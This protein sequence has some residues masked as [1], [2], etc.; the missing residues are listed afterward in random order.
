MVAMKNALF[1]D[2]FRELKRTL[3]RFLSIFA[4]VA[5][6]T[7]FFAGIKATSPDMWHTADRYYD[8]TRLEDIRLVSTLGFDD[9]DIAAIRGTAGTSGIMPAY[10][11]DALVQAG[12]KS[13]VLRLHSYPVG[14][15]DDNN[16]LNK[17]VVLEGRLPERSGECVT[18]VMFGSAYG[19]SSG[20]YAIG[21]TVTVYSG[22]DDPITDSL[23]ITN[24]KVVGTVMSPYY[25]AF[26]RGTT[27]IGNGSVDSYLLI[28]EQDFNL[29][30]Y[31]DVYIAAEGARESL[32]YSDAY[33][34]IIDTLK[35]RFEAVAALR[36]NQRYDG[37]VAEG[38]RKLN[39]AKAE[40]EDGK[41]E[42][43]EKL[44]KARKE[45]GD[46]K[47]ELEDGWADY[48][49]GKAEYEKEIA[50]GQKQ[51][52]DGY[53]EY[54]KNMFDYR[55]G[56]SEFKHAEKRA[57]EELDDAE[58]QL[59]A[60]MAEYEQGLAEYT[61]AK[62]L[63]DTLTEAL[64]KGSDPVALGTIGAIAQQLQQSSETAN[65]AALLAAYAGDPS[66]ENKAMA[67]GATVQ[68]GQ[69]L[70][71]NQEKLEAAKR[72]LDRGRAKISEGYDQL[73][74]GRLQLENAKQQL[75]DAKKTLDEK[76][77][78][79]K[80]AKADGQRELNDAYKK[81]TDGEQELDKGE[82]E[83]AD[84]KAEADKKLA[85]ARVKIE[86]GER[87][88]AELEPPEWYVL[89]R[90]SIPGN[91]GY[92]DDTQRID[93]ISKVFPVFFFL[94]A[95]LVCLTT[96][97]R[98][99][100]EQRTQIGTIKALGYGKWA[101]VSKFLLYSVTA[102]LLGSIVGLTVGFK[103]FPW[104]ISSAYTILYDTPPVQ[105][106]FLWSYAVATTTVA[107][108]CTGLA[109][110]LAC[111][112]ELA[113]QPAALMR[114]KAPKPGKRVLLERLPFIWK[115]LGF[116]TK[117][118]V[119]NLLRYKRRM[120]MTVIGI[121]GCTALMLT[122]FGLKN[123][124]SDI[125]GKQFG[126]LY[127]YDVSILLDENAEQADKD[128]FN[129]TAAGEKNIT[130]QID[131]RQVNLTVSAPNA[132]HDRD[133]TLFVPEA[134]QP[135]SDFILL[136][137]RR[138]HAPITLGEDGV[139]ITE[140]LSLLLDVKMGD[141][142]TL[143]DSDNRTAEVKIAAI[144]E[145]YAFHY[146]YMTQGLYE[147]L[148]G[149]LFAPNTRFCTLADNS[150]AAQDAF[151]QQLLKNGSVI[152]VTYNSS[153]EKNFKDI[154]NSMNAVVLVLIVSAGALAFIVLYNLTNIN[155]TERIRE[156]ATIKVLGFFDREVSAYI[157]RENIALTLLGILFGLFGGI[158]LHQFV[159]VKAEI[160]M[161]MFGRE[162]DGFSYLIASL[163]TLLFS[164]LVNLVLH[165]KLKRVSMVE[166]LKSIE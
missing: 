68:F 83:Y 161:V 67:D 128:A 165:F 35:D 142:L 135:I 118:T 82:Q 75:D 126:E 106:P 95:A 102:S 97:T 96:M 50:D 145:N 164:L 36:E 44:T 154:L 152:T 27:S 125:V 88:L 24:F 56:L 80:T 147:S 141:S 21:S 84:A 151:S 11:A 15:K 17:P 113:E 91:S 117:V 123:S 43:D 134:G 131:A 72:E 140:K 103:L 130:H 115:R 19:S 137:D 107:V 122:G 12:D 45:L 111:Y 28:P 41:K 159:I 132:A 78:E 70:A 57:D 99:V 66:P 32:S 47:A 60:G 94:V 166:S 87:Q 114:P 13:Q 54:T 153:I 162:I 48:T 101:I 42:A 64:A 74:E 79:F 136:R 10:T 104:V 31:T 112:K 61:A 108:L 81:L 77:E 33:N 7:G 119:R 8:D 92:Y 6:G 109:A 86:D 124:I 121:A 133:A 73:S 129:Q 163:L 63:C 2:S 116:T 90:D 143:R 139:V 29:P 160:D 9:D 53:N 30:V 127:R 40:Y 58:D 105:T 26:D 25:I 138:S 39:D 100:E 148:F 38:T 1:K 5:L 85:D 59:E 51:L 49:S 146:V 71:D 20:A 16:L 55:V 76:S 22:K 149:T 144:A 158:F 157:Y 89:D 155:V 62:G 65:L 110:L 93:A 37:L 98:M 18:E 23:K 46:A 14:A 156:I 4:I 69:T 3:G 52:D 150:E 120:L 34:K